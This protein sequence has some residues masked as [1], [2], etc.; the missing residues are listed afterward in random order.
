[1]IDK[2]NEG[3]PKSPTK[4]TSAQQNADLMKQLIMEF[5]IETK[6]RKITIEALDSYMR[7]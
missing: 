4:R 2:S 1:M 5:D 6:V 7:G 3:E